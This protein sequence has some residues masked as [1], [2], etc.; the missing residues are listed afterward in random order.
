MEKL[1]FSPTSGFEA[2]MGRVVATGICPGLQAT[3][4]LTICTVL[5]SA[6]T[7]STALTHT[8]AQV[9]VFKYPEAIQGTPLAGDPYYG[10]DEAAVRAK[11]PHATFSDIVRNLVLFRHGGVWLDNDAVLLRDFLPLIDNVGLQVHVH[12]MRAVSLIAADF[13]GLHSGESSPSS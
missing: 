10:R 4:Q 9:R 13:V 2:L 1:K 11:M 3:T 5:C 7:P 12:A 6:C 8:R